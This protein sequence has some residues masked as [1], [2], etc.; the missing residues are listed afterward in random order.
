MFGGAGKD[1]YVV[2]NVG[3]QIFELAGAGVD[4]VRSFIN[5]TLGA[6]LENLTLLGTAN[7]DGTGNTR[8]NVLTGNSGNNTLNGEAG[9]DTLNGRAGNDTLNGGAGNDTLNGGAGNDTLDGGN[10][11]DTLN[12]GN[13]NDVLVGGTGLD[14]LTGGAG[15]DTFRYTS[16]SESLPG[17][18]NRDVIVDFVGNGRLAGDQIDLSDV[19]PGTLVY[20]GASPFTG[21][22]Q[23]RYAGGILQV[24][25]S[26]DIGSEMAIQLAGAPALFV[27]PSNPG[28]D[29]IL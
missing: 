27:S 3:D 18:V 17:L 6:N 10:G 29:I 19:F 26:V 24:N 20:I 5:F 4:T 25:T 2:D 14:I 1:V 16:V 11:N 15:N 7:L 21:I 23:V 8:N 22:G 12:G 9:N 28:T 13:G